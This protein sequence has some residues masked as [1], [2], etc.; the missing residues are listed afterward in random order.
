MT[1]SALITGIFGQDGSYLAELLHSKGCYEI[2]GIARRPL[3][4]SAKAMAEFLTKSG[5]SAVLHDCDLKSSESISDLVKQL[6]PDECYHLAATHHSSSAT[7]E[8]RRDVARILYENNVLMGN[9]LLHAIA[10]FSPKTHLVLAGSCLMYDDSVITPQTEN[11]P[12]CSCSVYGQSKIAVAD[13]AKVYRHDYGIHVSNAILY[14]HESP[15][16]SASFVTRRIARH[17][18][19][20]RQ[21]KINSFPL[22]NLDSVRDWG[23]AKDYVAGMWLMAQQR[24]PDDYLFA[25]GNAHAVEDFVRCAFEVADIP[26]WRQYVDVD[27]RMV[28]RNS[29]RLVGNSEKAYRKLSWGHTVSFEALVQL[30]VE[31]AF[32]EMKN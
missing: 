16:R 32:C 25:T 7:E 9:N 8:Q 19:L 3:S 29:T 28:L 12:Y 31:A 24:D 27:E 30:M 6:K 11:L 23:Y 5:C 1:K 10:L 4:P 14:N 20:I 18:A 21:K 22:G 15:R 26:N 17:V 13:L 2:H